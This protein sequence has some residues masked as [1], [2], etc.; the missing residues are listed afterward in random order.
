MILVGLVS[1]TLALG[2]YFSLQKPT[3]S[4]AANNDPFIAQRF[5]KEIWPLLARETRGTSC[6][7]C[8]DADNTSELHFFSDAESSFTM[9]LEKGYLVLEGPDSLLGRILS[10]NP[11][12]RMPRGKSMEPWPEKDVATLRAFLT[13]LQSHSHAVAKADE[14]FPRAL[15]TPY[16][17]LPSDQFDN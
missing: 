1:F 16:R 13:D 12:K 5:E 15:L 4:A 8:H 7:K 11:R 6:V 14:Q 2:H 3:E 10:H 9:L 17:A